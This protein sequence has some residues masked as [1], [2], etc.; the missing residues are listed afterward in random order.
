[1]YIDSSHH[2]HSPAEFD[3]HTDGDT[4]AEPPAHS[5]ANSEPHAC[6]NGITHHPADSTAHAHAQRHADGYAN[7][8]SYA[9]PLACRQPHQS[10]RILRACDGR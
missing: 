6:T 4:H 10:R 7:H 3:A 2:P 5:T 9:S 1:M 8:R